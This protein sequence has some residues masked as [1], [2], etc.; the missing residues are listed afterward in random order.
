MILTQFSKRL[1]DRVFGGNS[2]G[3]FADF[4]DLDVV[5]EPDRLDDLAWVPKTV[6]SM[7]A[8][9]PARTVRKN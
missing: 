2:C 8:F 5:V 4:R 7:N 9:S 3:G 6:L 1:S